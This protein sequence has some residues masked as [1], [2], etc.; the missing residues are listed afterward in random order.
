MERQWEACS[1]SQSCYPVTVPWQTHTHGTTIDYWSLILWWPLILRC[2]WYSFLYSCAFHFS[3]GD[4]QGALDCV[5]G[6]QD[7]P[8]YLRRSAHSV[9]LLPSGERVYWFHRLDHYERLRPGAPKAS[10]R[11]D[12]GTRL[13]CFNRMLFVGVQ[14]CRPRIIYL[15]VE[16]CH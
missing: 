13:V 6:K 5:N 11:L 1:H 3:H 12:A 16:W 10:L 9:Q 14:F 2:L 4:G 15:Y 8:C 7:W